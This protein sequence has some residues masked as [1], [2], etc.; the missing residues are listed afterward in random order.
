MSRWTKRIVPSL[1]FFAVWQLV[2][3]WLDIYWNVMPHYDWHVAFHGGARDHRRSADG[4]HRASTTSASRRVDITVWIG[5]RRRVARRHRPQ[6]EGQPDP[7]Q[8]S[9]AAARRSPTRSCRP[10]Q[11]TQAQSRQAQHDRHRRRRHLRRG[12]RLRVDRRAPGVLHERHVGDSDDGRLRR[13]GQRPS[14]SATRPTQMRNITES[15]KNAGGRLRSTSGST[16]AMQLGRARRGRRI[17]RNLV[18]AS[19]PSTKATIEP[20]FGRPKLAPPRRPPAPADG[21]AG[22]ARRLGRRPAAVGSD[23]DD[24]RGSAATTAPAAGVG[25]APAREGDASRA[26]RRM[27]NRPLD[28]A[29]RRVVLIGLARRHPRRAGRSRTLDGGDADEIVP[30]PPPTYKA[31]KVKVDEHLGARV[32]LDAQFRPGWQDR[33]A[34]RAPQG[35]PPDD[36]DVQLLRLPDA[37]QP[38]AQRPLEGPAAS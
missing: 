16:M 30:P 24:G 34:R 3:H 7:D 13:S 5:A 10:C 31:N 14:K 38:A 17:L 8:G 9:D 1:V 29:R 35:R 32:P 12:A 27:P 18:P 36:P 33:H 20:I 19:A 4:Q 2:F 37:V 15:G 11:R 23:A 6:P 28:P 25:S 26:V 21:G 22:S